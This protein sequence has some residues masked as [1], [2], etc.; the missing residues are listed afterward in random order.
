MNVLGAIITVMV[1]FMCLVGA[2]A[3][4]KKNQKEEAM[5]KPSIRWQKVRTDDGW[6]L[7]LKAANHEIIVSGENYTD[8]RSADNA[9]RV[10]KQSVG[11]FNL[12]VEDVDERER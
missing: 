9:L 8:Q 1:A 12:K 6:H 10:I 4:V 7:R 2:I 3:Y 11:L 5:F